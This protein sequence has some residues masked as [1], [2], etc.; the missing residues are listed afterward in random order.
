MKDV[1][2]ALAR[3]FRIIAFDWDGTAVANRAADATP[4][5]RIL[6]RLLRAGVQVVVITGT[7]SGN[8]D[9]QFTSAVCGPHKRRLYLATNRGSEIFG[10][11]EECRMVP[12]AVR[13]ASEAEERLL[14]A[15]A[16]AVRDE[17][18]ARAGVA[19]DIVYNRVNRRKVDLIPVPPW[20]DPP[21]D[22]LPELVRAVEER[23][24]RLEG[25]LGEAF[26]I[27]MRT[28]AAMGLAEARVTSDVKHLEIGLT[29]KRDSMAWIFRELAEPQ[30]I[31]P[32]D[33]LIGGDEFGPIAG[34]P[35]SDS[36]MIQPEFESSVYVSV[37]PEPGGAPPPVL[38]L[39]GGPPRFWQV[40]AEQAAR[41]E[42][43][44]P[45]APN[46]DAS[47]VVVE[48]GYVG[49]REHEVE[50][51]QAVGNGYAGSRGSLM[52]GSPLSRPATF[53][54]GMYHQPPELS[55]P[56]LLKLP[57]WTALAI[58]VD[59]EP[60]CLHTGDF[61]DH[62][63]IL[64]MEQAVLWREWRHRDPHGRVT[65]VREMRFAS[66]ADRHALVHSVV[67]TPEN[68]SG[69]VELEASLPEPTS[70]PT[71]RGHE[72]AMAAGG[73]LELSQ[74]LAPVEPEGGRAKFAL[75]LVLGHGCRLDRVVSLHT[76]RDTDEPLA[77][78]AA[79]LRAIVHA[80]GVDGLAEA[81][82]RAWAELWSDADVRLP[83]ADLLE[84]RGLRFAIY[85]L[86]S[87][88]NPDD[89]RV[90]IG[91]RALTG[92]GYKGHVFWDTEI[93]LLPF[94]LYT[95][96]RAARALLM[97]R[98]HTLAAA[99]GKAESMGY[100]GALYAWESADT[101][102]EVT[103]R[104]ILTPDGGV[105]P[106]LVGTEE[107]HISADIAYAVWQYWRATGDDGFMLEAGTEI[108]LET[109]RFWA[110]RV[111]AGEDGLFHLR[112]VIGPD[113]FHE[114][115]DD[116]AYTNGMAAWNLRRAVELAS[117]MPE[118]WPDWWSRLASRLGLGPEE[119]RT[120]TEVADRMYT[121]FD[122]RTRLFE[123]H[124]GFFQLAQLDLEQFRPRTA[125]LEFVVGRHA[126]E[127]SQVLKQA[128]VVMLIWLLWDEFPPEVREANF[129][130]YEPRCA[131]DSSLSPAMHALVAARLG[132]MELARRYFRRTI[133]VDLANNMGNAAEGVH[134][135]ALGGLWQAAVFG[136][137]GVQLG[138]GGPRLDPRLPEGWQGIEFTLH[139]RGQRVPVEA[140]AP[141]SR[142]EAR[143]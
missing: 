118:R 53:L 88:V 86:L 141:V 116:N 29:D 25:G 127:S 123:Q 54:A 72:A 129:R 73:E 38:H 11:D 113:E 92:E 98:Y 17:I 37:G 103:P 139:W 137:A 23:L 142:T 1:A 115:V 60:L 105:L 131:H 49:A 59:G 81:H 104:F 125:P 64:D 52:E 109:A 61:L 57:D 70:F 126:L 80:R 85:H 130:Y 48:N 47:W 110:S 58:R 22:Q 26:E 42:I 90:S 68:W 4:V 77:A 93:F 69:I 41:H 108:V 12:L 84:Q 138:E 7:N 45:G 136:F 19:I 34:F 2:T 119:P 124:R 56:T 120:W 46:P 36:L 40:L 32:E 75:H 10:F 87:A 106:V 83:G 21:K 117:T 96:P 20:H 5:R 33:I 8:V 63:R 121:G 107:Q 24:V 78:A 128:D 133:E 132:D 6:E 31:A 71:G 50:S 79:H 3:R 76:S 143:R 66:Q 99:R 67:I 55:I 91:A 89:D 65:L 16:E 122:P 101:G 134:I 18:S 95:V 9:R 44:L 27:A 51:V 15:V 135:A 112:R 62:S 14:D 39:G 43:G 35:G 140:S 13:R 74:S 102:E 114:T 94:Y 100:R 97:Y 28:C 111:E 82:R 30:G